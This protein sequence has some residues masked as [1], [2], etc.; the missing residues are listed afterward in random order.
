MTHRASSK[1]KNRWF[2]KSAFEDSP[3]HRFSLNT[4]TAT[5]TK[6]VIKHSSTN[7]TARSM[8]LVSVRALFSSRTNVGG[9]LFWS[10][11]LSALFGACLQKTRWRFDRSFRSVFVLIDCLSFFQDGKNWSAKV[12]CCP[13]I[14]IESFSN[15]SCSVDT[16]WRFTRDRPSFVTCSSIQVGRRFL[17]N[18]TDW[19][20]ILEDVL[21]FKP[22]ELRTRWGR[23]GHIKESLGSSIV[24][25]RCSR[26]SIVFSFIQEH[27]DIWSVNSTA[28]SKVKTPFSWTCIN[29]S[30]PSGLIDRWQFNVSRT[31]K[32]RLFQWKTNERRW[33]KAEA[34]RSLFF[35]VG[36]SSE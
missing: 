29:E 22:I 30:F 31:N 18:S 16:R 34:V 33:N 36:N 17:L 19:S 4:P 11:H 23:R 5:N 24:V 3:V 9:H 28:S 13:L 25:L 27:T 2:F 21:W 6:F 32:H 10:D 35:L 8:F 26:W 1:P 12:R 14:Q 20:F 7:K 15:E